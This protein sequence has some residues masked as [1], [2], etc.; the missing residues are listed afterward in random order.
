MAAV[1]Y[2]DAQLYER[3]LALFVK[4]QWLNDAAINFYFTMIHHETCHGAEDLL[5]MDPAVASC[6]L[7]QCDDEDD[8][9]ELAQGL[10]LARKELI[11]L[12]VNDRSSFES[13]GSHWALLA[14]RPASGT[15][16][17]YDSSGQHNL[18]SAYEIARVLVMA[19]GGKPNNVV[20][21]VAPCPQQTNGVD[22]GMYVCLI[23]EWLSARWSSSDRLPPEDL[24][25]YVTPARIENV[26]AAMPRL[27][28][29]LRQDE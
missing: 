16:Q 8:L 25:A 24:H 7:L 9:T 23:A 19:L 11:V 14:Y 18:E 4:K 15:F 10:Q 2:H 12:P 27:V 20:L 26:R 1:L 3:D 5:L 17:Y 13:Q 29:A 21:Q 28:A 6:M 22:C